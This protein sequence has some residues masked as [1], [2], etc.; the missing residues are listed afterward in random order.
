MSLTMGFDITSDDETKSPE[1]I[2]TEKEH[3]NG[4]PLETRTFDYQ[5]SKY[6]MNF[7]LVDCIEKMPDASSITKEIQ[8]SESFSFNCQ[9]LS[10]GVYEEMLIKY[11]G[12]KYD[13][14]KQ[15]DIIYNQA[16]EREFSRNRILRSMFLFE[17]LT[18]IPIPGGTDQQKSDNFST[19]PASHTEAF[20]S[21]LDYLGSISTEQDAVGTFNSYASSTAIKSH[22][23]TF[24]DWEKQ[25]KVQS[26]YRIKRHG[27]DYICEFPI[28]LPSDAKKKEIDDECRDP[29][30]PSHR[31]Q[32]DHITKAPKQ[33]SPVYNYDDANYKASV[34]SVERKRKVMMIES[35]LFK[36]PGSTY[37]EKYNV[38][39]QKLVGDI[40]SLVK[41][42]RDEV[43][44]YTSKT[45][46]F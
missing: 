18:R 15:E 38:I 45:L 40:V 34:E 23:A 5:E 39:K 46:F 35:C 1:S 26:I 13:N 4:F 14:E 33:N 44:E 8:I 3:M 43:F 2:T 11:P 16:H 41:H 25:A 31:N 28:K 21:E 29:I 6:V 42:L 30:P 10:W 22:I 17:K 36:I 19:L 24:S 27:E 12:P 7:M 32:K 37:E 9:G 20:I